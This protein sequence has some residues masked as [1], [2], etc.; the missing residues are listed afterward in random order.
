MHVQAVGKNTEWRTPPSIFTALGLEFDLDPCWPTYGVCFVPARHHFTA[1]DDGLRQ[2]W[3]EYGSIWLNPPFGHP[4]GAVAAWLVKFFRHGNGIACVNALTSSDWFHDVVVPN[5]QVLCFP[6]G[7][8]KFYRADGSVG[9][10]PGNGVVLIAIGAVGNEALLQSGLG[11]CMRI[12]RIAR[13]GA[14]Q[15]ALPATELVV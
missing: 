8:T 4:R 1:A 6:D 9:K 14:K 15:V 3:N 7:K 11:A 5:A 2:S 13:D 12:N 10:S